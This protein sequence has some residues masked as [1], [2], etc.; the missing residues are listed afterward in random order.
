MAVLSAIDFYFLRNWPVT[1]RTSAGCVAMCEMWPTTCRHHTGCQH[2][3]EW[4]QTCRTSAGCDENSPLH[5][6]PTSDLPTSARSPYRPV[7][8]VM[9]AGLIW[10]IFFQLTG[11]ENYHTPVI[12]RQVV[13]KIRRSTENRPV[14][15]RHQA[16]HRTDQWPVW[17]W[18][19]WSSKK[20]VDKPVWCRQV[21]WHFFHLCLYGR[22][23]G[24]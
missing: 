18:Q 20:S 24:V 22:L 8:C 23:S 15:C 16:G 7:T 11:A 2:E 12:H 10:K 13:M 1:C 5:R 6:K 3:N 17:C 4:P 21:C 19:V 14:T 9:L